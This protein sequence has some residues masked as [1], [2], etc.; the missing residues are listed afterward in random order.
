MRLVLVQYGFSV[1]HGWFVCAFVG[2][3]VYVVRGDSW[4][5]LSLSPYCKLTPRGGRGGERWLCI[6]LCV[7]VYIFEKI[8]VLYM[9]YE[10]SV[11]SPCR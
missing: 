6:C 9:Y 8:L 4:P 10:R 7:Y 3:V 11:S 5:L 2:A 1:V